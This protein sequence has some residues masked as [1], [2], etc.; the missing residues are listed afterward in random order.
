MGNFIYYADETDRQRCE[1]CPR[2]HPKV[3][4]KKIDTSAFEHIK[5]LVDGIEEVLPNGQTKRCMPVSARPLTP[6]SAQEFWHEYE[7]RRES[8]IELSPIFDG[9]EPRGRGRPKT[10]EYLKRDSSGAF[11]LDAD[12][13]DSPIPVS[14]QRTLPGYER[15]ATPYSA[16]TERIK[17]APK[18]K[19][20]KS[21][22]LDD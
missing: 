14:P 3:Y 11:D 17:K 7:D 6:W 8:G 13:S 2:T 20:K 18:P 15:V 22:S 10:V 21:F 16:R 5:Y 1:A 19:L 12:Y 9:E 4:A